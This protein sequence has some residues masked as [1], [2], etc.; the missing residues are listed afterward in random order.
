MAL[1]NHSSGVL[2]YHPQKATSAFF[3]P[4]LK[5]HTQLNTEL[6]AGALSPETADN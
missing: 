5:R 4:L 3:L 6:P 1:R 2:Q